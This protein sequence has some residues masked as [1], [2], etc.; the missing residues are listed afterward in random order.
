MEKFISAAR[1]VG[2]DV[3][4][5]AN[6]EELVAYIAER[7]DGSLMVS[8][9]PSLLRAGIPDK[10]KPCLLYTSDAADEYQRV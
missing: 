5:L 7:V 8:S 6:L 1:N 9:C 2:A 10:L 3:Q 4:V